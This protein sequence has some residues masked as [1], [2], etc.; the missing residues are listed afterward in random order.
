MVDNNNEDTSKRTGYKYIVIIKR[1]NTIVVANIA[2][3]IIFVNQL[4]VV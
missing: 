3:S 1:Q 4:L 2:K